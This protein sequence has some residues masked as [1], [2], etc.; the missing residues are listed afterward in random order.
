MK[1]LDILLEEFDHTLKKFN[2]VNYNK[3]Q[4][5][6]ADSIIAKHLI[7]LEM[8]DENF[9]FLYKW[10]NGIRAKYGAALND[11]IFKF[12]ALLSL[13][14]VED[15]YSHAMES[16]IWSKKFIP[17]VNDGDSAHLLFNNERGSDY[18]KIYLYCV[19]MLYIDDPISYYDSIYSMIETTSLAYKE[20]AMVYNASLDCLDIDSEKFHSIGENL[21]PNSAFWN[22]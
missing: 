2:E 9:R 13:E 14:H 18:G 22:S 21:N 6:L 15:H 19:P 11:D 3:L 10:K 4:E 5:P 1:S 16:E 8:V 7:N 17:I 20:R 12:G